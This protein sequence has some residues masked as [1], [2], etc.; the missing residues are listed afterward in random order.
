MMVSSVKIKE[1]IKGNEIK[2][3]KKI[4]LKLPREEDYRFGNLYKRKVNK[5]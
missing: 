1:I 5:L 3:G 4:Y 2:L